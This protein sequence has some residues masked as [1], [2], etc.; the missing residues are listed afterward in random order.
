MA[1]GD[2]ATA[3]VSRQV[4]RKRWRATG[5]QLVTKQEQGRADGAKL[6]RSCMHARRS[7]AHGPGPLVAARSPATLA[8]CVCSWRKL[9][10]RYRNSAARSLI[11]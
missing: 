4:Q 6:T 1:Y 8:V 10:S 11:S 2:V 7:T 3:C 9:A 5:D